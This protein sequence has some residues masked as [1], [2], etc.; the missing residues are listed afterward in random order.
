MTGIDDDDV[1]VEKPCARLNEGFIR[2]LAIFQHVP[3]VF[4]PRTGLQVWI[5]QS[6]VSL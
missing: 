2:P 5:F 4:G 1:H 3:P 6:H